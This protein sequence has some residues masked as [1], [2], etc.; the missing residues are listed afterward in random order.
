MA[1]YFFEFYNDF[2]KE[3]LQAL[4]EIGQEMV[5]DWKESVSEPYPPASAPGHPPHLR[6]G[7]LRD[8][9]GHDVDEQ[10]GGAALNLYCSADY[11]F[12]LEFGT[13]KMAARPSARPLL[14]R[15]EPKLESEYVKRVS[16]KLSL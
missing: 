10:Q 11:F 13:F 1:S 2:R 3:S 7:N 8:S 6:T 9:I 16:G 12:D 4:D 14:A 5:D 15:W